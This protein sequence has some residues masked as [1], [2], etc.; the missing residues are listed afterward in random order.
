MSAPS[1]SFSLLEERLA[2][3]EHR[4]A[5]IDCRQMLD[6]AS[7]RL[8]RES[9][10]HQPMLRFKRF[11]AARLAIAAASEVVSAVRSENIEAAP[12]PYQSGPEQI[13]GSETRKP[14]P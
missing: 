12:N 8:V 5:L 3:P 1:V 14:S 7:V 2:G 13:R 11:E 4:Q 6:N 10:R 9:S